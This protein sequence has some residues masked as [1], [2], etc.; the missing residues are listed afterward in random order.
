MKRGSVQYCRLCFPKRR[1]G[2]QQ[3]IRVRSVQS[4]VKSQWFVTRY[5]DTG[6]EIHT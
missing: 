4:R 3:C 5:M 1:R 2:M 6:I